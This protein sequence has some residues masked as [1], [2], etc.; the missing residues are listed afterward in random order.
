MDE[1][2]IEASWHRT[3]WRWGLLT[4]LSALGMS[5]ATGLAFNR[6]K[7]EVA[8]VEEWKRSQAA[9]LTEVERRQ[10]A[11]AA[12]FQS[13][14]LEALGQLTTGVAHDFG[15]LLQILKGHLGMAKARAGEE[16]VRAAIATCEGAVQRSEKLVQH[17]LAFARRQPLSYEIFDLN[18][19]LPAMLDALKQL[20]SGIRVELDLPGDLWPVEGDPTQLELVVINLVANARDAMPTGGTV[21]ITAANRALS[22]GEGELTGDF[23]AVHVSDGGAGIP[24]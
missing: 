12:L 10:Q 20:G 23:V 14:K 17:L 18:E 3:L 11:E 15:N 19:R 22:K 1:S 6:A 2:F 16:R 5:L 8:T 9:L 4:F 24:P 7:K 21:R 13:Q